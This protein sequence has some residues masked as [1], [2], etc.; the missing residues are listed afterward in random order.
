[1]QSNI[2]M[3]TQVVLSVLITPEET[4]K[5]LNTTPGVL[6]VWRC[7]QRYPLRY[8]KV[9]RKVMYRAADVEAFLTARTMPGVVEQHSR[10][11]RARA[12]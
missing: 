2:S 9:G 12:R 8:V 11:T 3:A 5:V 6:A 1:M 4:A 10:R 7:E